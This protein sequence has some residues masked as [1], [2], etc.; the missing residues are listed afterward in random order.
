MKA[1]GVTQHKLRNALVDITHHFQ[2]FLLEIDGLLTDAQQRV[3]E[4]EDVEV[5]V[6][7]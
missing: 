4:V 1:C 5:D 6:L 2:L 3:D 7:Q